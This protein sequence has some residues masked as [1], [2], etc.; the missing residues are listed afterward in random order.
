MICFD[1]YF[2]FAKLRK[3]EGKAKYFFELFRDGVTSAKPKIV[4]LF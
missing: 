2:S 3:V 1:K 4:K